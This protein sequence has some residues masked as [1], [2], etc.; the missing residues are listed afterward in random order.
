MNYGYIRGSTGDVDKENQRKTISAIAKKRGL[1]INFI[2]DTVSSGKSFEQRQISTLI[3]QARKDDLIL[4]AE[5]SRFARDTEETLK[6][7]RLALEKGINLEILNPSIRFDN[8][9]ATKAIITVMGLSSEMER[10]FIKSRTRI[11]LQHRKELIKKNGFFRNKDGEKVYQLGAKKGK[12]QTLKLEPKKEIIY[13][14]LSKGLSKVSICKL[15]SNEKDGK[16][17][18]GALDRFLKRFPF[19]GQKILFK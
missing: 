17:S 9:I 2:E 1:K 19:D 10:Y 3:E 16:I 5:L 18:R 8:S 14:Y 12:K 11:S 15:L 4:V 13:D 7:G 6:I